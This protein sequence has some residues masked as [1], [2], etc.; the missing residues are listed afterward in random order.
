MAGFACGS[1]LIIVDGPDECSTIRAE[2]IPAYLERAPLNLPDSDA[3]P[4]ALVGDDLI[5]RSVLTDGLTQSSLEA[6]RVFAE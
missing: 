6:Q 5:A 4:Y 3:L 1:R 2:S